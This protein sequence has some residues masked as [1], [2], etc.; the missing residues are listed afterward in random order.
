MPSLPLPL[1]ATE[2]DARQFIAR[3]LENVYAEVISNED[4]SA[5]YALRSWPGLSTFATAGSGPVRGAHAV[6]GSLYVVSGTML[7]GIASNGTVTALGNVPGTL[8]VIMRDNGAQILIITD[9][10]TAYV[11]TLAGMSLNQVIDSNYTPAVDAIYDSTFFL[12]LAAN[13]KRRFVSNQNDGESYTA[14]DAADSTTI[15]DQLVGCG[16][17]SDDVWVLGRTALEVLRYAGVGDFPFEGVSGATRKIGCYSKYTI[18]SFTRG[19]IWLGDDLKVYLASGY[20][21]DA[22]SED[23]VTKN[24]EKFSVRN[25][26]R[27]T[28]VK[29]GNHEFYLLTFPTEQKT[30]VYDIQNGFWFTLT[31]PTVG[32]YRACFAV[33][34]YEKI[35]MGDLVNGKI[36]ALDPSVYGQDGQNVPAYIQTASTRDADAHLTYDMLELIC[37]TGEGGPPGSSTDPLV[38]L[39]WS[40]DGGKSFG[41]ERT[42][43]SNDPALGSM[44]RLFWTRLGRSRHHGRIFRVRVSARIAWAFM[45]ANLRVRTRRA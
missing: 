38:S 44:T 4:G 8:P 16:K 25:D 5:T 6:N 26:A 10:T 2:S 37:S 11:L 41:P 42:R 27:S 43:T 3:R 18:Q 39:S 36:Y 32:Y 35:L 24:I 33:N 34:C 20:D 14:L 28:L 17:Y 21:P 19:I 31:S 45:A 7:Y 9:L 30:F 29:Q 13:S 15:V 23:W 12:L 22:I 40:D 1:S